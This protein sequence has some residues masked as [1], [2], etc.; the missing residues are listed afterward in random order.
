MEWKIRDLTAS[1]LRATKRFTHVFIDSKPVSVD[2]GLTK[3]IPHGKQRDRL[4]QRD[5][6]WLQQKH[7]LKA[8]NAHAIVWGL[9]MR[10]SSFPHWVSQVFLALIPINQ[11]PS[12]MG[13]MAIANM[14][15]CC[16]DFVYGRFWGLF[17]ARSGGLFPTDILF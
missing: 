2:Y 6:F 17:M 10:L 9:G 3:S 14:S 15:Q 11:Q 1:E 8:Q 4:K 5:G 16:G 12:S 7:V 13:I